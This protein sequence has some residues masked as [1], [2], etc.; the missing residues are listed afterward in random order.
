MLFLALEAPSH[1]ARTHTSLLLPHS[2]VLQISHSALA[3]KDEPNT[4]L[5]K[6]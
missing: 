5:I 1:I 2:S 4:G 3:V 6:N